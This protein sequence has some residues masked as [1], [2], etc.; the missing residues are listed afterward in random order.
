[1]SRRSQQ[2]SSTIRNAVQDVI[3]RGLHDP[4]IQGLITVTEVKVTEDL[5]TAIVQI[6]VLPK[7]QQDLTLHG[8]RAAAAH[9]R[10]QIGDLIELKRTPALDIRL[11]V[12][13]QKEAAVLEALAKVRDEE[14]ARAASEAGGET[15]GEVAES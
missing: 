7:D 10:H 1:M 8:L 9:I 2:V 12:G 14:A 13:L 5:K 6:S 15:D 3:S 11:D 4:R